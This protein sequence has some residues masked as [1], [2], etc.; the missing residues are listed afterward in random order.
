MFKKNGFDKGLKKN[1]GVVM[2]LKKAMINVFPYIRKYP[3]INTII[4][5]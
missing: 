3:C 1:W 4:K 5:D 2:T